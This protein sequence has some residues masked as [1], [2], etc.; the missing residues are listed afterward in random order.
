MMFYPFHGQPDLL[1]GME[2]MWDSFMEQKTKLLNNS[3]QN[4]EILGPTLYKH[5]LQI[6]QN[7]QDLL[8]K[9]KVQNGEET[10]KDD[11][12]DVQEENTDNFESQIEQLSHYINILLEENSVF[13]NSLMPTKSSNQVASNPSILSIKLSTYTDVLPSP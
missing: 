11:N 4:E 10:C 6:L 8:N 7:I 3:G 12:I 1:H 2:S 13:N 9:K 5:S